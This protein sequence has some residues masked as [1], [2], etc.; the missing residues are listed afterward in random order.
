MFIAMSAVLLGIAVLAVAA[1]QFG[2]SA[3][4][5]ALIKDGPP[6]VVGVVIV[7]FGTSAPEC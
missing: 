3:A 7:G 2:T 4:R 6:L 1:D 5:V